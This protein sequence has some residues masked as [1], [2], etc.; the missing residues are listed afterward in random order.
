MVRKIGVAAAVALAAFLAVPSASFAAS[1]AKSSFSDQTQCQG[2]A[3]TAVN[4]DRD[5]NTSVRV[6]PET[7]GWIAE[8]S[9]HEAD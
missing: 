6:C 4:P 3:C 9:E 2:G 5:P 1:K 7:L 8:F